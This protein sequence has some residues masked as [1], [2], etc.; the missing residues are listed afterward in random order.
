MCSWVLIIIYLGSSIFLS[1]QYF[2]FIPYYN[3]LVSVFFGSLINLYL[4]IS[5]NCL[6]TKLVVVNGHIIILLMGVPLIIYLVYQLRQRR[7]DLL[8]DQ[9]IE[10][11]NNDVDALIQ[12]ST[13]K[14]LSIGKVTSNKTSGENMDFEMK[15]KG[16][17][18]LHVEEC[19]LDFCLCKNQ[20]ELYDVSQQAFLTP[21]Q[22]PHNEPIFVYHYNKKLFDDALNKFI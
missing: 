11:I 4:W 8:L 20:E 19:K 3:S 2:I 10:K 16:I 14:D 5:L 13:I 18:N 15:V 7:I 21:Q 1:Y 6:L 22:E 9:S 17:I 12:I